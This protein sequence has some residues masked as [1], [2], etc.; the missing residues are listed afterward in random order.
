[1][2][3]TV[4]DEDIEKGKPD[5]PSR[6][7]IARAMT[8]LGCKNVWVVEWYVDYD[9]VRDVQLPVEAQMFINQ[10]DAGKPVQPI[11]FEL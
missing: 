2:T 7:P 5:S 6:C 3:I 4:T 10:F 1:M 8:R 11:T 9:D